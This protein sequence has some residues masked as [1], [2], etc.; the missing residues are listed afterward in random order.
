M[1]SRTKGSDGEDVEEDCNRGARH[2]GRGIGVK[3]MSRPRAKYRLA[4][5][6]RSVGFISCFA[7]WFGEEEEEVI[8]SGLLVDGKD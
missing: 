3:K 5:E 1:G 7:G 2:L 8:Y 4:E 6:G